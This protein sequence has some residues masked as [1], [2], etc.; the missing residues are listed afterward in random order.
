LHRRSNR[1]SNAFISVDLG[2]ITETLFES[3]LFGHVKGAF[4]DARQDK[5]GR[6]EI[7]SGGTIFLD[8]VGNLTLPLQAKL[9]TVL[10]QRVIQP[11][12]SSKTISVD[13]RLISATNLSLHEM[14]AEKKFRQDLLYRLNT[15]EIRIPSLR[16]RSEDIPLLADHFL[17]VYGKKY[18]R[19][20]MKIDKAV[21]I[22][23]KKY[24]WPGNIRELQHAI[25][26]A[27]ILNEDKIIRNAEL[28]VGSNSLPHKNEFAVLT[29]E[30]M[31]KQFILQTL[32]RHNGNVSHAAH[33]LGMTRTALYRRMKKHHL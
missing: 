29:M 32:D 17:Q 23:M 10:Q 21:M 11:V 26:R 27:V 7:A 12:G 5:A 24:Y 15:V 20:G 2:A 6:F 16:E 30:E 19:P 18:K 31:E 9:L 13:V 25:E 33:A 4:T 28:V 22:K 8:E 3:E 1:K 14:T